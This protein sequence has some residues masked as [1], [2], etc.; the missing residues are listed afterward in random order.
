MKL[1]LTRNIKTQAGVSF[2]RIRFLVAFKYIERVSSE[3]SVKLLFACWI[4][5]CSPE[6]LNEKQIELPS[7]SATILAAS[8]PGREKK[9]SQE[10]KTLQNNNN[11]NNNKNQ[12]Q[13]NKSPPEKPKRTQQKTPD[14]PFLLE[15][16]FNLFVLKI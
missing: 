10:K 16:F 15:Y 8:P 7:H 14:M 12:K 2:L 3:T 4:Y 1:N 5:C 13:N 6:Y 11:K 9:D